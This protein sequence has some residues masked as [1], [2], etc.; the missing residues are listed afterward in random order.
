LLSRSAPGTRARLAGVLLLIGVA[1]LTI[2]D[3][4]WAHAIGVL[5]LLAFIVVG[6]LAAT[7][8][9]ITGEARSGL[10]PSKSEITI[11]PD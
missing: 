2:A 10:D 11:N 5:A 3:A 4:G 6:F 1:F 9:Q 7:P 8:A